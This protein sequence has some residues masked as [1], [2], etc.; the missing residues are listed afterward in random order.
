MQLQK[1]QRPEALFPNGT[2]IIQITY[3]KTA[4]LGWRWPVHQG[5]SGESLLT[6]H[7]VSIWFVKK[8]SPEVKTIIL[9]WVK[10]KVQIPEYCGLQTLRLYCTLQL[11]MAQCSMLVALYTHH[12]LSYQAIWKLPVSF[13]D[14][15][16][17]YFYCI[18]WP[19]ASQYITNNFYINWNYFSVLRT[20]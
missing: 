2:K 15:S 5:Q 4:S 18:K 14:K 11:H 12:I 7:I 16:M 20:E 3:C 13:Q 8:Q 19:T 1:A 17:S 10:M 9:K 6:S